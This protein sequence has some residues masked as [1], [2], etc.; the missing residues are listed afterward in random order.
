MDVDDRVPLGL[1][2]VRQHPVAQ[3]AGV[4]DQD[5]EVA[6]RVD[7]RSDHALGTLEVGDV[8]AVGDRLTA[9]RRDLVDHLLGRAEVA[10]GTVDRAAEVVDDHL[11]AVSAS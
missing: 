1:G 11:G 2:H 7:R 3:D 9:H 5:V 4:V 8:L 10:A 6:E